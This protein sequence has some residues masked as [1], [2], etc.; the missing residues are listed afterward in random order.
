MSTGGEVTL[1]FKLGRIIVTFF[2]S[3][4]LIQPT[5]LHLTRGFE[6]IGFELVDANSVGCVPLK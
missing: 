5:V 3:F 1:Q 4:F 2:E 6:C